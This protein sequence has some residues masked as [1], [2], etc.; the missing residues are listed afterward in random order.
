MTEI[1]LRALNRYINAVADLA[2]SLTEDIVQG[3]DVSNET[4]KNLNKLADAALKLED[5]F[6]QISDIVEDENKKL[7]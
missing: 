4:L 2:D 5:V 3:A 1:S 7:N 6:S